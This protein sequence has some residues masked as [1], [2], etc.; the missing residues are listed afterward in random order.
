MR[1]KQKYSPSAGMSI[2]R[3]VEM[4]PDEEAART[5]FELCL[6][7]G[8]PRCPACGSGLVSRL[9]SK[10]GFWRCCGCKEQFSALRNTVL[11]NSKMPLGKWLFA[12]YLMATRR[13]GVSSVQL[14]AE[15]GITQK[16][17]WFMK[18]RIIEAMKDD[19]YKN[20]LGGVVEI[21][22][23]FIGGKEKN[24][25]VDKRLR[26]GGG[27][28]GKTP[29]FG[30]VERG[31]GGRVFTIAAPDTSEAT[32]QG[33]AQSVVEK[34]SV[35]CTDELKSY[36]GLNG[37]GYAHFTV[38]HKAKQYKDGIAS[39]N[40]IE[41]V[42][43]ALKKCLGGTLNGKASRKHLQRYLDEFDFRWNECGR[44]RPV[45]ERI[46][47]LTVGCFGRTLPYK[48]L[49]GK[50]L[51]PPRPGARPRLRQALCLPGPRSS[52]AFAQA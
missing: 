39:T 47:A 45:M 2:Y 37:F 15:L 38:C 51:P 48:T 8:N 33:L 36:K 18:H 6:W 13:K 34:D 9:P 52:G 43:N 22:E 49:V 42:W 28:G 20:L 24:K 14:G 27:C 16:S 35:V 41:S 4:F 25:H 29:V 3:F 30:A 21:D 7:Q 40:K 32:L 26:P 46:S 50:P 1:Q 44:E 5:F 31:A 12:F 11:Q 10:K 23:T 19:K 17:A